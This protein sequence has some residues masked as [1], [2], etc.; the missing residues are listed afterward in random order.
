MSKTPYHGEVVIYADGST[1]PERSGAG[2]IVVDSKGHV[3]T[4]VNRTLPV[5][6]SNEAEYAALHLALET[7]VALRTNIIEIRMDNEVVVYQMSGR[8]AVNSP[9][10]KCWHQQACE[11]ARRLKLV[12]YT[13][14]PRKYN[15]IADA[16]ATEA[17]AG[18]SWRMVE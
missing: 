2:V 10:L 14:I 1:M 17:S 16:L 7:A 18:R 5:M 6:T 9:R 3:I 4:M 15:N 13:H 11:L 8:F 12:R